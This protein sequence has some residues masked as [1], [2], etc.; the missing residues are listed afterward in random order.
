MNSMHDVGG[1]DGFGPVE[2]EANEPVFHEPW[3][4]RM[5]AVDALLTKKIKAYF[6]DETRHRIE[7]MNPIYYLGS[8]YYQIWLLRMESLLIEKN[9]VTEEEIRAKMAEI[10]P[11]PPKSHLEPFRNIMPYI[12]SSKRRM[13]IP[14]T[15]TENKEETIE[16]KYAVGDVVRVKDMSPLGHTRV[17]RYVRGK[18]GVIEA[19]H[20]NFILP[21]LRVENGTKLYQPVYRLC[22]KA[23]D[24][25][26]E[27]ASPK[28][29]L[30]IEMWEDYLEPG[31]ERT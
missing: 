8:S 21:D 22:F 15:G 19:L 31:G 2:W 12:S 28:D 26:G 1:I 9:Y 7:R 13:V 20:G 5:R 18:E 6:V 10:T 30:Y 3:E 16:P 24:L 14:S 27:D 29:K 4:A 17:P 25:W 23:Q 11:E